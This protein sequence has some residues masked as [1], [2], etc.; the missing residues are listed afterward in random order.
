MAKDYFS[1][2]LVLPNEVNV[3]YG[4]PVSQDVSELEDRG[5][6]MRSQT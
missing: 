3:F 5:K 4:F 6:Q 2:T 1:V